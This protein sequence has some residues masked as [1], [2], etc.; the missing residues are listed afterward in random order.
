MPGA[1]RRGSRPAADARAPRCAGGRGVRDG[2]R[3]R[4]RTRDLNE[5]RF[6]TWGDRGCC[7]PRGATRRRCA[8]TTRALRAGDVLVLA[9][10]VSP[11]DRRAPRT[12]TRQRRAAVRLVDVTRRPSDPSGGAVRCRRRHA[13]SRSPRSL[14]RRRRAA[15]PALPVRGRRRPRDRA[16]AGATSCSPTTAAPSPPSRSARCPSRDCSGVGSGCLRRRARPR[17]R[18]ASGRRCAAPADAARSRSRGVLVEVPLPPRSGRARR[19]ASPATCSRRSSRPRLS[20]PDGSTIR[21]GDAAVVGQPTA[22]LALCDPRAGRCRCSRGRCRRSADRGRSARALRDHAH[23][24]ADGTDAWTPQP[25]LLAATRTAREFVVEI[26]DDGTA[27]AALRRR[28]ARAAARRRARPSRRPTASATASPATSAPTR[29][30][31]SSR[32]TGAIVGVTQPA[33][34]AGRRR[35]RDRRRG[36]PRRARGVPRP[37]ARGHRGRLRRGRRA[38]PRGAARRRDV[39]LDRQLAHRVRHR[40]PRRRRARSTTRS[41]RGLRAD[42]ERFRMAGYDLEVDGPRL[43]A[44]RDRAARLR[45]CPDYFRA[46]RRGR[47]CATCCRAA[48]AARRAAAALPPRQLHV[49]PAGLPAPRSS[50]PRRRS[51]GVESVERR[52]VPAPGRARRPAALDSGVLPM[53]RLEIARLD[54]DP[55]FPERGRARRSTLGG[56]K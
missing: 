19:P 5:L 15:V 42:L 25:D 36:P 32:A 20:S 16:G 23:G 41:R 49:R 12:P 8:A 46:R 38:Q 45:R 56:G 18:R 6:Y 13:P 21:G 4:A 22:R 50:P 39:P 27:L 3:R 35:S 51:T 2:R 17:C 11:D 14:G 10:T 34:G 24:D 55:N 52:D 44:A 26:E 28:R 29:S 7:L 43:R 30:P 1:A 33:A 53:G 31:T 54:N 40:R 47:G 37:G 48:R 9:E